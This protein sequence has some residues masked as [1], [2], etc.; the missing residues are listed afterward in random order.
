MRITIFS[1]PIWPFR[2]SHLVKSTLRS[3]M[4]ITDPAFPLTSR[5]PVRFDS[6]GRNDFRKTPLF[7]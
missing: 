7:G 3:K 1:R 5:S 4:K 6:H 2:A